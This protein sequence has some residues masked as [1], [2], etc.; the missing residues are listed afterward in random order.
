MTANF[1]TS[2]QYEFTKS[3]TQSQLNL[4]LREENEQSLSRDQIVYIINSIDSLADNLPRFVRS[5]YCHYS[6]M[7]LAQRYIYQTTTQST[8]ALSLDGET[9]CHIACLAL[10]VACESDGRLISSHVWDT[11]VSAVFPCEVVYR[12][13]W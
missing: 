2:S 12:G 3:L 11:A 13:I 8:V 9:C 6:A 1:W 7:V 10:W 4:A 5:S